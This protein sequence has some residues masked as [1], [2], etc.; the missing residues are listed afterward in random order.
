MSRQKATTQQKE[1]PIGFFREN[2]TTKPIMPRKDKKTV[3]RKVSKEDY[4]GGK[5]ANLKLSMKT[6]DGVLNIDTEIR[7]ES[8]KTERLV[9]T[10]YRT[11]DGVLCY[12]KYVGGVSGK[13]KY[14]DVDGKI[15][16]Q[17]EVILVQVLPD[18]SRKE[19]DPFSQSKEIKA[20]A[21]KKEIVNAF[22]PD[23]YLEI[24]ADSTE[25][26]RQLRRL[27]WYLLRNGEVAAVRQFAK[28]K[29]TKAY[30]GFI[31][32]VLGPDGKTFG[33]EMM[34]S[35][36]R[37]DRKRWMPSEPAEVVEAEEESEEVKPEVPELWE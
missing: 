17:S 19:I 35:E 16:D 10:E 1:K 30:V 8:Q 33:L 31:Y 4:E 24:W 11:T 6:E 26:Q 32:P 5:K 3:I 7:W 25:G 9:Q 12:K 14:V 34:V 36:N 15:R 21:R 28:A 13:L 37:R 22:L 20:E 23:S 2:G 29:G 27:A 18:G